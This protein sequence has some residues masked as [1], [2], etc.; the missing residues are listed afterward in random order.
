MRTLGLPQ[1]SAQCTKKQFDTKT[2]KKI[3]PET[4]TTK[5]YL[6]YLGVDG[7]II[8]THLKTNDVSV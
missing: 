1:R 8:F 4:V 5:G 2:R 6:P 3:L 7:K